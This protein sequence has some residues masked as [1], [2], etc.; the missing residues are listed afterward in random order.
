MNSF[1]WVCQN[2][3]GIVRFNIIGHFRLH[4]VMIAPWAQDAPLSFSSFCAQVLIMIEAAS[5]H[6]MFPTKP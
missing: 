4:W 3:S 5:V 6:G 2:E 1:L